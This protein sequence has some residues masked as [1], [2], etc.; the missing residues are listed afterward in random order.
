MPGHAENVLFKERLRLCIIFRRRQVEH[1]E[2]CRVN[3]DA[4]AQ[5]INN[6]TLRQLT[7]QPVQELLFLDVGLEYAQLL[8]RL[9][10]RIL[11]EAEQACL[12]HRIFSVVVV[13][14]ALLVAVML[15]QP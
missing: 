1:D 11:Q 14:S 3:L 5:H 9:R 6:A 15:N 12:V 13:I 2:V 8:Q 7:L 4:I 10:L